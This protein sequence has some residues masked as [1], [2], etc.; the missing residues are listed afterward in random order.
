MTNNNRQ[1]QK[2]KNSVNLFLNEYF[3]I[4]IVASLVLFLALA[5]FIVLG[6]R[7][8]IVR[9][10][11]RTNI[12][13][14]KNLYANNLRKLESYRAINEVYKKM[15][16]EDLRRFNTVLPDAYVPERLFGE[17][18]EIVSRGGWLVG[19][20]KIMESGEA[21]G[22][23]EG[24]ALATSSLFALPENVGQY[25]L[26]LKVT[27]ID[28]A[29]FQNLLRILENNLRLFDIT[30]VE[31]LPSNASVNIIMTTYYYKRVQ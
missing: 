27:A 30:S 29:D 13:S 25:S 22:G 19:G 15:N 23:T 21:S 8:S 9:E 11:I 17:I 20:L 2:N 5:Y 24:A 7:F 10:A 26:E 4:I 14:E 28:Y 12:E 18:E 6:P 31:F 3:R 1:P 16:P